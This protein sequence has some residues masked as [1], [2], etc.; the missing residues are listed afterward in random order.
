M[1][2]QDHFQPKPG[3]SRKKGSEHGSTTPSRACSMTQS[4]PPPW[5]HLIMA[6]P[7]L[8][9]VLGSTPLTQKTFNIKTLTI[10]IFTNIHIVH[11][12]KIIS[13]V[14]KME[15]KNFFLQ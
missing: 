12:K 1:V 11:E 3:I 10:N 14:I 13:M 4:P 15:T 2:G 7:P 5:T 9:G 8:S 6:L